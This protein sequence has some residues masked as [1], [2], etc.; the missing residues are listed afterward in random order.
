[1]ENKKHIPQKTNQHDDL[2]Y[3]SSVAFDT[4]GF[5][6][7][8][9]ESIT[10]RIDSKI[11]KPNLY[12]TIFISVLCG[13]L[14]GITGVFV[15]YQKNKNHPS[16]YQNLFEEKTALSLNNHINKNDTLF[17]EIK[18]DLKKP[19][20]HYSSNHEITEPLLPIETSTENIPNIPPTINLEEEKHAEEIR[21]QFIPNAPVLFINDLKVTN[22]QLYYFKNNSELILN[23]SS[24]LSAEYE[25]KANVSANFTGNINKTLA[26][27]LIRRAMKAFYANRFINCIEDLDQLYKYNKDD[28]NAQFYLGSCYFQLKKYALAKTYFTKNIDNSNNIFHQESEFYLAL[29]LLNLNDDE[30][31]K[32]QLQT[33]VKNNGFYSLRAKEALEKWK[34]D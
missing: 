9:L 2:E 21:F 34:L 8:D 28:A 17:P 22:Y 16:V 1:M 6:D 25:N 12:S 23:K 4:F 20:E 29:S 30:N 5:D 3:L 13:L 24:G 15:W 18:T 10:N 11:T 27:K 19:V 33:I 26:H 31:A 32:E 7:K 14:I